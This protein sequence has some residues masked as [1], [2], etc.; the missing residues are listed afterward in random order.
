MSSNKR[1]LDINYDVVA[2]LSSDTYSAVTSLINKYKEKYPD[3]NY[4]T[5]F[6]GSKYGLDMA[7]AYLSA[8][9]KKKGIS[10]YKD[11]VKFLTQIARNCESDMLS[12]NSKKD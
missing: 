8:I 3:L 12:F 11:I 2:S 4:E 1:K 10:N 5:L 7:D 6:V 9:L